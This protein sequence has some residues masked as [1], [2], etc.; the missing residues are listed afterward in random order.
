MK[1]PILLFLGIF[2]CSC[3]NSASNE[4]GEAATNTA[5]SPTEEDNRTDEEIIQDIKNQYK[6]IVG[7]R[8]IRKLNADSISYECADYPEEGVIVYY[9]DE[10]GVRLIE[11]TCSQGDH[12]G[13]MDQYFVWEG[14]LFFLYSDESYWTFDAGTMDDAVQQNT[15]D[16]F[17]ER[18]YYFNK[19]KVLKCLE[20]KYEQ[21]TSQEDNPKSQNVHNVKIEATDSKERLEKFNHLLSLAGKDDLAGNCV[22]EF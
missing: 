10:Q 5:P 18:R 3:T 2:I 8:G 16:Y 21:R 6:V 7:K 20:K 9:T 14:E 1:Y 22:W 15:V 11:H 12:G 17:T 13:K 4:T 19:G